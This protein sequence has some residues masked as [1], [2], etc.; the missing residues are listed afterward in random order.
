MPEATSNRNGGKDWTGEQVQQLRELAEGNT[1]VGVMSAKLGRT[2]DAIR[3][4]A[5]SEGITL[6]PPNRSPYGD[7][8]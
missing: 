3:S 7:M 5:Q 4:K 6:A 8:S 1:P 2:E